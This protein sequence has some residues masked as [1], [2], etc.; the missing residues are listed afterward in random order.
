MNG[1]IGLIWT[2]LV[3]FGGFLLLFGHEKEL[4]KSNWWGVGLIFVGFLFQAY[5]EF[6]INKDWVSVGVLSVI[7]IACAIVWFCRNRKSKRK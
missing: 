7:L 1:Y 3:A 5:W 4:N 2:A 6:A